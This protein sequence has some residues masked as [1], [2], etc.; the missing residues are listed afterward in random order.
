MNQYLSFFRM[1]F[2]TGMQYRSAALAGIVTQF[3]WGG[4]EI[5]LFRAFYE[6]NPSAFPMDFQALSSYI[7][8]Q[9]A[10][11]ALYMTWYLENDIFQAI[12][13]GGI[14]YEMVRPVNIYSMWFARSMAN[15]L[16]KAVL[17]CMPILI[18]AAIL[19]KPYGM[20]LP[21]N[22]SSLIWALVS[23]SL[24]FLVVVAFCMIIY[25]LTFYTMT[26][27]GVRLIAVSLVE[28][29]SGAVIPLP[30]LPERVEQVVSLLPFASMQNVPFRIYTGNI[31][32]NE[33][34]ECLFLQIFWVCALI[35]LGSYMMRRALSRVRIQGG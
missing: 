8:L 12:S 1:R 2:V 21:V 22:M 5:L 19:K 23:M 25:I 7:W 13:G 16:S 32:G 17:R 20:S 34:Y 31:Y 11:L 35:F 27:I 33:I 28:F 6:A 15:R 4:L 26:S 29:L 30:F 9:Q 18:F 14:A 24:S 10:F 3:V